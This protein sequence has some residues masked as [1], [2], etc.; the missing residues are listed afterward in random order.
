[1]HAEVTSP[2]TL[3]SRE[4]E[5]RLCQPQK[6]SLICRSS[7]EKDR[8][9]FLSLQVQLRNM[10]HKTIIGFGF[11][12]VVIIIKASVCVIRLSLWLRQITQTLALI[13][14]AIILNLMQQLLIITIFIF[15]FIMIIIIIIFKVFSPNDL[16]NYRNKHILYT[17]GITNNIF[18][19]FVIFCN[20]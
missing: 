7:K 4:E 11:C 15:I 17:R 16:T 14:I 5:R 18:Y 3:T 8:S 13:I 1:M 6:H 12:M 2:N 19:K 9:V 10:H 20:V